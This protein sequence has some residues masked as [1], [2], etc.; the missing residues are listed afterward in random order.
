[1]QVSNDKRRGEQFKAENPFDGGGFNIL[2]CKRITAVFLESGL[3]KPEDLDKESSRPA[4][5]IEDKYVRIGEA[6]WDFELVAEKPVDAGDHI[7]DDL[8]WR[9]PYAETLP[10]LRFEG[11]KERLVE[12]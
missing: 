1:L 12:I 11:R 10:Q 3:N 2:S 8:R 6:V 5:G 4:T 7:L 9:E